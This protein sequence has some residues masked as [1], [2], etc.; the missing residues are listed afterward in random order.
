MLHHKTKGAAICC[1]ILSSEVFKKV[2]LISDTQ[3]IKEKCRK[4]NKKEEDEMSRYQGT[5]VRPPAL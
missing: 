5:Q 1:S 2:Y 4:N 3:R